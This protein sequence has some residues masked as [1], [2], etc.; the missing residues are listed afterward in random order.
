WMRRTRAS[1][2]VAGVLF[3]VLV[4][5]KPA[6][7]LLPIALAGAETLLERQ[8]WRAHLRRAAVVLGMTLVIVAPWTA[9]N[10]R[11]A[12]RFIPVDIGEHHPLSYASLS[13][14]RAIRLWA[15]SHVSALEPRQFSSVIRVGWTALSTLLVLIAAWGFW[16]ATPAQR[17]ALLPFAVVPLYLTLV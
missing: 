13:T 17:R 9:R 6:Y 3:G 16:R 14:R 2:M 5:A 10:W 1:T 8:L 11:V 15:A 12:H 7:L 4:L